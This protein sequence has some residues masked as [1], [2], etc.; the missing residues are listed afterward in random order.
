MLKFPV[1]RTQRESCSIPLAVRGLA[2][3]CQ[4]AGGERM[5][6]GQ[7][8]INGKKNQNKPTG[9]NTPPACRAAGKTLAH[10]KEVKHRHFHK[11]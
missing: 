11:H 9:Q 3:L 6:S 2:T 4:A 5:D 7:F 10:T 8:D 1:D